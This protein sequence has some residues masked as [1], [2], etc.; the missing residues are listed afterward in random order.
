MAQ[1]WREGQGL[2]QG[3]DLRCK[4]TFKIDFSERTHFEN[5]GPTHPPS[6]RGAGKNQILC[7]EE[8]G[9][10]RK[11]GQARNG[12]QLPIFQPEGSLLP[13]GNSRPVP[14]FLLSTALVLEGSVRTSQ[15]DQSELDWWPT[16]PGWQAAAHLYLWNRLLES[17]KESWNQQLVN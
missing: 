12:R 9:E 11:G 17:N 13:S 14:D 6:H 2:C 5:L 1:P 8:H 4:Q 16:Q 15:S 7:R 3:T 10:R